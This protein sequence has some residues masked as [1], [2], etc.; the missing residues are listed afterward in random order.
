MIPYLLAQVLQGHPGVRRIYLPQARL[1]DVVRQP[2][3][4]RVRLV[5]SEGYVVLHHTRQKNNTHT[6]T[7]AK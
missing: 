7:H 5:C 2:L 4:E 6:H 3:D 1:D